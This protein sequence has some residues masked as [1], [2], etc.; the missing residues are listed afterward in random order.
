MQQLTALVDT[1]HNQ[2]QQIS[3][4]SG[5]SEAQKLLSGIALAEDVQ[6]RGFLP[7]QPCHEK[8]SFDHPQAPGQVGPALSMTPTQL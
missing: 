2:I 4:S 6:A 5:A 3:S 1:I 8:L 7:L